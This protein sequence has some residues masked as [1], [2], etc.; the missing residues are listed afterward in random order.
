[1]YTVKCDSYRYKTKTLRKIS[2]F[3][4]KLEDRFEIN[5]L[6]NFKS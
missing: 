5:K 3:K 4:F 6:F 1:M 2:L